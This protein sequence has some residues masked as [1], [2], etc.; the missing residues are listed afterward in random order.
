MSGPA[1]QPARPGRSGSKDTEAT[2]QMSSPR[3]VVKPTRGLG[4]LRL[5]DI[6]HYRDLLYFLVWRDLKVRYRQTLLGVAWVVVQPV[7]ATAIFTLIFGR[8]VGVPSGELPYAV[9]AFSGLLPWN[10]FSAT[11]TRA[12]RSLVSN[13][14]LVTK[15]YFPRLVIPLA[16]VI[17]GLA[18][19]SVAS[20]VSIGLMWLYGVTPGLTI[21]LAPCIVLLAAC[22]A[23]GASLWLSALGVRFRD[24]EFVLPFL[25]QVWLYATPVV[26]PTS[27][28]PDRWRP[29]F[30]LNPM[31]GVVEGFRWALTGAGQFPSR[32]LLVSLG[33]TAVLVGSGLV[34]FRATERT[35]AD[36]I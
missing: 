15:V 33:V 29:I 30:G 14:Q 27:V 19:L 5:G 34:F 8:L 9:F 10:Y 1:A 24:V 18:D 22:A 32:L 25:V 28:V 35:F 4:S 6:W 23:F 7:A 11:L 31:V 36:I 20:V 2:R 21:L 13:S 3:I 26:Y 12:G 17:V 16:S